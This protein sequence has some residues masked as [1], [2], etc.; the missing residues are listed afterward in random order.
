MAVRIIRIAGIKVRHGE[1]D[2]AIGAVLD[3]ILNLKE[4][5]KASR[6][7]RKIARSRF[8]DKFRGIFLARILL[9]KNTSSLSR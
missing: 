9:L 4:K 7:I 1:K 6:P 3:D 2:G 8:G 5:L